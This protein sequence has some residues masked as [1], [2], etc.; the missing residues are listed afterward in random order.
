MPRGDTQRNFESAEGDNFVGLSITAYKDVS[1]CR[2]GFS[3]MS[4]C[5]Y[6]TFHFD[7]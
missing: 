3:G 5:H 6:K 7:L 1:Y 2:R 4:L